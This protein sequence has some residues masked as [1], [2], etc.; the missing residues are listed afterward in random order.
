MVVI[1]GQ[2][3]TDKLAV[4]PLGNYQSQG[5][6][7]LR[8]QDSDSRTAHD[9]SCVNVKQVIVMCCPTASLWKADYDCATSKL[10]VLQEKVAE[11]NAPHQHLLDKD[12]YPPFVRV[13]FPLWTRR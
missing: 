2:V 9:M 11:S 6:R 12:Q 3:V 4:D 8:Y 1:I 5:K 10:D 13:S 7:Q